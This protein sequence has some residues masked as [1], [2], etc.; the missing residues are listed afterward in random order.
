MQIGGQA[1]TAQGSSVP[2]F[3]IIGVLIIIAFVVLYYSYNF[4]FNN[5]GLPSGTVL[6]AKSIDASTQYTGTVPSVQ[7]PYEGGDYTVSFWLFV[8]SNTFINGQYRKHIFDIGGKN[9]STVAI[10]IDAIKNSLIV[11]THSG[12]VPVVGRGGSPSDSN[13]GSDSGS[14]S[15]SASSSARTSGRITVGDQTFY[16][17]DFPIGRQT[18]GSN[19]LY[20]G[21]EG[22]NNA[23]GIVETFK[24]DSTPDCAQTTTLFTSDMAAMFDSPVI[25]PSA[26]CQPSPSCDVA[27]FD[28]QRWTLVTVVLSGKITDVYIDGKLARSCIGSSYYKVDTISVTPNILQH[29]TFDG[30]IA[31]LTLYSLG[32][33]P[34]QIYQIYSAGP[35]L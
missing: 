14:T 35:Q 3:L 34:A 19:N 12:T 15:G 28:M 29:K 2:R 26:D 25:S 1:V 22:R 6:I 27:E 20:T 11:R 24:T 8:S 18:D 31:N 7:L 9:F 33:N 30:K 32:L 4:L 17:G 13:F 10:G 21:E 5:V 23:L 16:D